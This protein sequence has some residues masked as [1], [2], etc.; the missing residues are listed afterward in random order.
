MENNWI[1]FRS[2]EIDWIYTKIFEFCLH[3][4]TVRKLCLIEIT[5]NLIHSSEFQ[6]LN[7]PQVLLLARWHGLQYPVWALSVSVVRTVLFF[8]GNT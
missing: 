2:I 4:Q 3:Y 6:L 7:I 1:N 8:E 5:N